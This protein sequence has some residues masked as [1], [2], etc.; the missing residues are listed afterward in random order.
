MQKLISLFIFGF[1]LCCA[2]T[3]LSQSNIS[4]DHYTT[5]YGIS[6]RWIYDITQDDYGFMWF[7]T[8]TGLRRYDGNNYVNFQHSDKNVN[9]LSN[10][11]ILKVAKPNNEIIWAF[12]VDKVFNRLNLKTGNVERIST[13]IKNEII[14]TDF[15]PE[16]NHFGT[17]KNGDF[18][19]LLDESKE[20]IKGNKFSLWKFVENKNA[21]VHIVDIST[22]K[23]PLNYFT[24]RED[25]KL[26][27]WGLGVEYYLLDLANNDVTVFIPND[28]NSGEPTNNII[29]VDKNK[30]FW[31]PPASTSPN[32]M[33]TLKSFKFPDD[34][35]VEKV[36]R[37]SLDNF[38]NIWFYN[39]EKDLYYFN[40]KAEKLEKF[41]DPIFQKSRGIQL[42]YHFF[43]DKDGGYWNGHFFGAIRFRKNKAL[44]NKYLNISSTE[45]T[46]NSN[47][48][49][50]KEML[51]LSPT[52]L[53]I[54]ENENEFL[55]LNLETHKVRKLEFEKEQIAGTS[56]NKEFYSMVLRKDGYLW[57]NQLDKLL[58]IDIN[59]GSV[60][61]YN[62]PISR[63]AKDA[64]EDPFKK[65][66]P[67]IFEDRDANLWYCDL[68]RISTFNELNQKLIPVEVQNQPTSVN[69]DFKFGS[70]D[71][72]TNSIYGTYNQG[73]YIIDCTNKSSSLVEIFSKEEGYDIL[74]TAIL[75]W[76]NEFWLSTNKG[77]IRFDPRNKQKFIYTTN[78]GLPSNVV[79]D[80]L[81]SN[82]TLWIATHKGLCQFEP[83]NAKISNYY[84]EQGLP[85][86]E[87]N[88]WSYLET[89]NGLFYFGGMNG[90]V[91][92]NPKD[93]KMS[94]KEGGRLNL[95]GVT[96]F[97]QKKDKFNDVPNLPFN[98]PEK[99]IVESGERTITF[100]YSL[101]EY[102]AVNKN[103]YMHFMEGL[104]NGWIQDGTQNEVRYVQI[105][106]GSYTFKVA[107]LGPN[108]T[109]AINE[110]QIPIVVEQYWYLRWWAIGIY[111]L[112]F[113]FVITHAYKY[114]LKRTLDIKEAIRIKELDSVKTRMYTNITHE[115]R[116]PLTVILGMN[117]AIIN[118][119][120]EGETEKID[121]AHKMINR[122]GRNLLGLINQMLEL[123]K[124]ESGQLKINYLQGNIIDYLKYRLE[125]F[126]S[127]AEE[128]NIR[129]HY[130][131]QE[132][133]ILMD[134]DVDKISY[135][136][137]NLVSNAIKFSSNNSD[138]YFSSNKVVGKANQ[139][140]LEIIVKDSGIGISSDH[141]DK[142]FDRFY[143]ADDSSIRS[144]EGTGIGL[145]LVKEL[146]KLLNGTIDVKSKINEGSEFTV[147]LPITNDALLFEAAITTP[148]DEWSGSLNR[149]DEIIKENNEEDQSIP[150]V[151]IVEDN[152]DVSHYIAVSIKDNY[153]IVF[154]NNGNIGI[155]KAIEQIPDII[156][157][158]VMM[159]E[160]N[161]FELC[162]TLKSDERTSHIPII[163]LT[164]KADLNSKIEGLEHG[165]DV[166][167]AK[168]FNR[169]EL[170]IRLKNLLNLR[171]E[172]Q[173]RYSE[174][175]FTQS[176][177][178]LPQKENSFLVKIKDIMLEH[179][180]EEEFGISQLCEQI[181]V[182]RA[183]LHRKLIALTGESTSQIIRKIRLEKAKELLNLGEYNVSE[184]AYMVGFKTQA[185]FSRVFIEFYGE[186][187]SNFKKK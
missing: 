92:F 146:V 169:K 148:S 51:E 174:S 134:F 91:G 106:P 96:K 19:A 60:K 72:E 141:L 177:S 13:F 122:N 101:T 142:I 8:H 44:F 175:D 113:V 117:D 119:A 156:I 77:L 164:G 127:Y 67:R 84:K 145:S 22:Q 172:I 33:E 79:Y 20:T 165:A 40:T 89:S 88:R 49:R 63:L 31:Y 131:P 68:E 64:V 99:I 108:K 123:S 62:I 95:I 118:Y 176:I 54:K 90:I 30:N 115:F 140:S 53:L 50:I 56:L 128:K 130:N 152:A 81:G 107:A 12:S 133:K 80:V 46:A 187:P 35:D 179:L 150:L 160:K 25:G 181:H 6:Y 163:L 132:D 75:K 36:G 41:E 17:L 34:V 157:S 98:N 82:E 86:N 136:V 103:R 47:P 114:Q 42:M 93:F 39:G 16:L 167:L 129:I 110:I 168:P 116:T 11:T 10:N 76:K 66:F 125:S 7:A 23:V 182:S 83:N 171:A 52:T 3:S 97:N 180:D 149:L 104:D 154:A 85:D 70:Y 9:T 65:Y 55:I 32:G 73:V 48:L 143:Q 151:L 161:G 26:W 87:F 144:E 43:E 178:S 94:N 45:V 111:V 2:E 69:T 184:V 1:L 28:T 121:H 112:V 183:Q 124:I 74:I 135:I 105:P 37:M 159:P 139:H 158:D 4:I 147:H 58:K 78:D 155:D 14:Q 27:L 166:Y 120:E 126:Q 71:S 137:G 5:D 57:T 138:I 24:E 102:D 100:N 186:A 162:K 38:N 109:A 61:K 21:F 153:R 170:L 59:S 15:V 185:H 29:L 18:F 173:K